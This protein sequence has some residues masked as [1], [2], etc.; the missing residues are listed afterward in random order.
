MADSRVR[1]CGLGPRD[2]L[3]LEAGLC[4]YGE[5]G[6]L[7]EWRGQARNMRLWLRGCRSGG[8]RPGACVRGCGIAGV[9]GKGQEH[10]AAAAAADGDVCV[11]PIGVFC[12]AQVARLCV[13]VA[14]LS[15]TC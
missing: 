7:P 3:R 15:A 8:D 14:G 11:V 1:M 4:L 12:A 9:E 2:S 5:A 6:W 13:S 10:V